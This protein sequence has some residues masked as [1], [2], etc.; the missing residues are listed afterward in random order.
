[1]TDDGSCFDHTKRLGELFAARESD[2]KQLAVVATR[3]EKKKEKLENCEG[4]EHK[5]HEPVT[6][7]FFRNALSAIC[8]LSLS[9]S[10]LLLYSYFVLLALRRPSHL[11]LDDDHDCL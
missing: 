2:E 5:S 8:S 10:C 1:M 11:L 7:P 4:I 9:L 3:K 6:R